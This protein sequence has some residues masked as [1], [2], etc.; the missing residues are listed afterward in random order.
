MHKN[1][2]I[3]WPAQSAML[4]IGK[5]KI[6]TQAVPTHT[7]PQALMDAQELCTVETQALSLH[8]HE[9]AVWLQL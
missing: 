8:L 9:P 4:R 3:E 6:W 7:H 2:K 1:N 5:T